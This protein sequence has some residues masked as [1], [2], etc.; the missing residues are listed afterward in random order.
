MPK[1]K[2]KKQESYEFEYKKVL[3]VR[4]INYG[5][6]LGNDALVSLTHEARL[7]LLRTLGFSELDLG[8]G[9]TGI[10]MADLAVN[11]LGEG[12]MFDE[13]AIESHIDEISAVSFRIFH[14]FLKGEKTIALA[15]TGI[16]AFDYKERSI[17]S[18]PE[19]FLSALENY[20]KKG[21]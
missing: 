18:I 16:I 14:H 2:L 6:H 11:Y 17:V 5:G 9:K 12:F 20:I 21:K 10:I 1:V 19:T 7:N 15:E 4:D 8:D 3:Q 13:L